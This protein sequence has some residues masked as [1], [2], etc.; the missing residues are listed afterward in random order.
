MLRSVIFHAYFHHVSLDSVTLELTETI[1]Q[2]FSAAS[3]SAL[4]LGADPLIDDEGAD[5][6]L[7]DS[8]KPMNCG[9]PN[10]RDS[11]Y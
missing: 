6:A 1:S 11:S 4:A 8:Q 5:A 9:R 7:F 10:F 3:S 2:S